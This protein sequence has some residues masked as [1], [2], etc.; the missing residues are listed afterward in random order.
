MVLPLILSAWSPFHAWIGY[1][2]GT[3]IAGKHD[4]D[5]RDLVT[6]HSPALNNDQVSATINSDLT[7]LG[8]DADETQDFR[9]GFHAAVDQ[10]DDDEDESRKLLSD[11]L[12]KVISN[13]DI[14]TVDGSLDILGEK[15]HELLPRGVD[16]TSGY[17]EGVKPGH[18]IITESTDSD[19]DSDN[20][21]APR[22]LDLSMAEFMATWIEHGPIPDAPKKTTHD[23]KHD[24]HGSKPEKREE[25]TDNSAPEPVEPEQR[26]DQNEPPVER[27]TPTLPP[28][29]TIP[30]LEK[31]KAMGLL[32]NKTVRPA[33]TPKDI[34][35]AFSLAQKLKDIDAQSLPDSERAAAKLLFLAKL[36][37]MG[38]L[39]K[40]KR[41]PFMTLE[42][43]QKYMLAHARKPEATTDLNKT[44]PSETDAPAGAPIPEP[45]PV[46]EAQGSHTKR[47]VPE[48]P[49]C[50]CEAT[51][52]A[53]KSPKPEGLMNYK[54][55]QN[56]E[57]KA[58]NTSCIHPCVD[59]AID[60]FTKQV[61]EYQAFEARESLKP[62]GTVSKR[63]EPKEIPAPAEA[64]VPM[65]K[66]EA[67]K[68]VYPFTYRDWYK[69]TAKS[70]KSCTCDLRTPSFFSWFTSFTK[71][72]K[73]CRSFCAQSVK[74]FLD[75]EKK[76]LAAEPS[77][78]ATSTEEHS[79]ETSPSPSVVSVPITQVSKDD[80][81]SEPVESE[82]EVDDE[83]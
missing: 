2:V 56:W 47:S 6:S 79:E 38:L 46:S 1:M 72:S 17:K 30:F 41:K 83:S 23:H 10:F 60:H 42:D 78:N 18:I 22:D 71:K 27:P 68:S 12:S 64:K 13:A 74:P 40:P 65:T 28:G 8:F 25:A 50:D 63:E 70:G 59:Q 82:P 76:T 20:D 62:H 34:F 57:H 49:G 31:A 48:V 4:F 61:V 9:A 39:D 33:A 53:V 44:L 21:L 37:A 45:V 26:L 67:S 16:T 29:V 69:K 54:S 35:H 19:S 7:I 32:K 43:F 11:I 58:V 66:N 51:V 36:K 5:R 15:L 24:G 14:D 52:D 80:A 3:N 77:T 73:R 55:F 81:P 75:K